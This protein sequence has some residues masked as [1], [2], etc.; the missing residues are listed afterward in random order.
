MKDKKKKEDLYY[1]QNE[2]IVHNDK[3]LR[4]NGR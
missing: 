4:F 2:I 1:S 3:L